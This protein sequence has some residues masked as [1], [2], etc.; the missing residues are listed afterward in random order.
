M[1]RPFQAS[2]PWHDFVAWLPTDFGC[3]STIGDFELSVEYHDDAHD[4]APEAAWHYEVRYKGILACHGFSIGSTD[5]GA[6]ACQRTAVKMAAFH[7]MELPP[8]IA[9]HV[10][11]LL[12][13]MHSRSPNHDQ[14]VAQLRA[15]G[16]HAEAARLERLPPPA[17]RIARDGP[18]PSS[19]S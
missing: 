8:E 14:V 12:V 3:S 4:S 6:R 1:N 9:P 10:A 5:D 17:R 16:R 19:E 11:H 18:K 2:V 15:E 13:D 7:G